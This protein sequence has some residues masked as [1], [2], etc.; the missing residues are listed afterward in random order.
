MKFEDLMPEVHGAIASAAQSDRNAVAL[1]MA[2]KTLYTAPPDNRY[3]LARL[4][5]ALEYVASKRWVCVSLESQHPIDAYDILYY[6][7][8]FPG[9]LLMRKPPPEPIWQRVLPWR[10]PQP[11]VENLTSVRPA[12]FYIKRRRDK[13]WEWRTLPT[14]EAVVTMFRPI[15]GRIQTLWIHAGYEGNLDLYEGPVYR[16]PRF[17]L[18]NPLLVG[19]CDAPERIR[20]CLVVMERPDSATLHAHCLDGNVW[21]WCSVYTDGHGGFVFGWSLTE[22]EER[23]RAADVVD[24]IRHPEHI[25]LY[26]P[27]DDFYSINYHPDNW[28]ADSEDLLI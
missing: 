21:A 4:A 12:G 1:R 19:R 17:E 25:S 5:K 7:G 6:P 23:L 14:I 24:R 3:F 26:L 15:S 8:G 10:H 11:P 20:R 13:T 22:R 27:A 18:K 16:A 28:T 2:S 9:N